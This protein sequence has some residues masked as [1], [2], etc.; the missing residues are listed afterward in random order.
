MH[1]FNVFQ[2]EEYFKFINEFGTHDS[3]GLLGV[4]QLLESAEP[5]PAGTAA[6][7][8]AVGFVS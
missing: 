5:C 7:F 2:L 4:K 3:C 6:L 1:A 8:S